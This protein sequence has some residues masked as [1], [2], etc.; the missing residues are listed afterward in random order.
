MIS[1][2]VLST[3]G[4]LPAAPQAADGHRLLVVDAR[5]GPGVDHTTVSAAVSAAPDGATVLIREGSY[6]E[7]SIVVA[8]RSLTIVGANDRVELRGSV[9]VEGLGPGRHVT[10]A[11]LGIEAPAF[12]GSAVSLRD[13]AGEIWIEDC[14]IG[15][16]GLD[17]MA[18]FDALVA[19]DCASLVLV[20]S[21]IVAPSPLAGT[22]QA[23]CA[24][25]LERSRVHLD[26]CEI[27]GG[28]SAV[29]HGVGGDAVQVAGGFLFAA[30]SILRGGRGGPGE[31]PPCGEPGWGGTALRLQGSEALIVDVDLVG[32]AGG[33]PP[34]RATG[35]T[36]AR[37]TSADD[38]CQG[39]RGAPQRLEDSTLTELEDVPSD[40]DLSRSQSARRRPETAPA[41]PAGDT[42]VRHAFGSEPR[43]HVGSP[44]PIGPSGEVAGS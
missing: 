17:P 3:L 8:D 4:M 38:D 41:D 23:P 34:A 40:H 5:G 42:S 16:D 39:P 33:P 14:W 10:L 18:R 20:D 22:F 19:S 37:T 6:R 26:Q 35:R 9:Q 13:N 27:E 11:N 29:P 44:R 7:E 2:L 31:T 1:A 25:R 43:H 24:M 21:K 12:A 30:N 15:D 36:T 28:A 32:G